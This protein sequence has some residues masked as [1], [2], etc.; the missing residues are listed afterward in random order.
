MRERI[1]P[2][3]YFLGGRLSS[4]SLFPWCQ[5]RPGR[6]D[7]DSCCRAC[8]VRS[9][10]KGECGQAVAVS[11]PIPSD[12]YGASLLR[13]VARYDFSTTIK[14]TQDL[15][16]RQRGAKSPAREDRDSLR[17]LGPPRSTNVGTSLVC[18]LPKDAA[19]LRLKEVLEKRVHGICTKSSPRPAPFRLSQVLQ[20]RPSRNE[21]ALVA[22]KTMQPNPLFNPLYS[23]LNPIP[24]KPLTTSRNA[25]AG[26]NLPSTSLRHSGQLLFPRANQSSKHAPHPECPHASVVASLK[27]SVQMGQVREG[28]RALRAVL[29]EARTWGV[30]VEE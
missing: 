6:Y 23:S 19:I 30:L 25:H 12:R 4:L 29:W 9:G 16:E 18:S 8:R 13:D 15:Q 10:A 28:E 17:S 20:T 7:I 27:S 1:R 14:M 3:E 11:H 5:R 2:G 22:F 21:H 26:P 24:V